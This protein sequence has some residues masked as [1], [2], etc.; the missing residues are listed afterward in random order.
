[1]KLALRDLQ[2]SRIPA[3]VNECPTSE[4]FIQ[5]V[6]ETQEQLMARGRWFGTTAK[7]KFCVT[8]GCL[9]WPREVAFIEGVRLCGKPI[10]VRNQWYEF[11]QYIDPYCQ[12]CTGECNDP[13][14]EDRGISPTV[15]T[16]TGTSKKVVAYSN[17]ADDG[18][19][20]LVQGK[21][22]NNQWIRTLDGATVVDGEYLILASPFV[23]STSFFDGGVTGIQKEETDYDVS[24][25]QYNTTTPA[26]EHLLGR[27]QPTELNPSYRRSYLRGI[28]NGCCCPSDCDD[29]YTVEALATLQHVPVADPND[30]LILQNLVAFKH[31]IKSR[32]LDEGGDSAGAEVELQKA[33]RE[34]RH[35]LRTMTGDKTTIV[36]TGHGTADPRRVF[37]GFR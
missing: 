34:L 3:H 36:S 26:V 29:T 7:A 20:I 6:N 37:Q 21:D 1:M 33:I 10:A 14:L 22:A 8:E 17:P 13:S 24:L 35:Q 30:W 23:I 4:R 11:T 15:A 9:T 28:A 32:Q 18:K 25:Y 5:W 12:H 27:Y 31:G 2:N 19:T 16:I